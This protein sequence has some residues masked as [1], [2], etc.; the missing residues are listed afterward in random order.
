MPPSL[1]FK[2]LKANFKDKIV[3]NN[4]YKHL[5]LIKEDGLLEKTNILY[6]GVKINENTTIFGKPYAGNYVLTTKGKKEF[7][8]TTQGV[9]YAICTFVG[10]AIGW[11]LTLMF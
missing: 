9:G 3:I 11:L 5:D 8:K 10:V 7:L 1:Y 4:E 2:L 6:K